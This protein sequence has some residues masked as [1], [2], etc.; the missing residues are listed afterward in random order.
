MAPRTQR[1]MRV[2]TAAMR[3]RRRAA[4]LERVDVAGVDAD[5]VDAD[6]V[7]ADRVDADRVNLAELNPTTLSVVAATSFMFRLL[8][9]FC[10]FRLVRLARCPSFPETL[11]ILVFPIVAA[12]VTD[13]FGLCDWARK[14]E[15]RAER[16]I[17]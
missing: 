10:L 1:A 16:R 9:Y 5:R 15:T 12:R 17:C 3:G 4:G 7:D 14:L 11:F 2:A 13:A 6:K 8:P